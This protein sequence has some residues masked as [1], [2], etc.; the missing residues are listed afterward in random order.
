MTIGPETSRTLDRGLR[1]LEL[2]AEAPDGRTVTELSAALGVGRTVIYRLL[3][4]LEAHRMVRRDHDG[5][6]RLSLGVLGLASSVHPVLRAAALPTLRTLAERVGLT[7]ALSMVEGSEVLAV[8]VAEPSWTDMHVAYREGTRHPRQTG[9]AGRAIGSSEPWLVSSGELQPGAY[10]LAA[11]LRVEGVEAS[12]GV[13]GLAPIDASEVGP[14][15]VAAAAEL[16]T[17]LTSGMVR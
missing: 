16:A 6:V 13:V 8:A 11:P 17:A 5:R 15:V 9:A 10:G 3:A 2:L 14:Q 7:A 4:T 1:L 12:V